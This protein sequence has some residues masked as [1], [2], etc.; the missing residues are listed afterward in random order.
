MI[1]HEDEREE[2][3]G[4]GLHAYDGSYTELKLSWQGITIKIETT[5]KKEDIVVLVIPININKKAILIT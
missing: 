3:I 1:A 5:L 2:M 4:P